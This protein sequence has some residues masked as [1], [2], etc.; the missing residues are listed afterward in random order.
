MCIFTIC[1]FLRLYCK[2]LLPPNGN[3]ASAHRKESFHPLEEMLPPIGNP[4]FAPPKGIKSHPSPLAYP[5]TP[6]KGRGALEG[7]E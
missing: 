5:Q 6:S 7:S 4:P 2:T 3:G 1:N